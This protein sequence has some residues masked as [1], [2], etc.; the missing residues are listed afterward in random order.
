MKPLALILTTVLG[1]LAISGQDAEP[2]AAHV[3]WGDQVL[4]QIAVSDLE[5]SIAFYRDTLGL[6]FESRIDALRWARFTLP[7]GTVLGMGEAEDASGSGSSSVNLSVRDF[8]AAHALLL[9]RGVEFVGEVVEIPGVVRLAEFRDPDGNR[10]QL[11][12]GPAR[13]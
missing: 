2:P 4:I 10:L 11:A 5:Q 13:R 3:E 8:D 6:P 12:G 1:L 9:S 7:T